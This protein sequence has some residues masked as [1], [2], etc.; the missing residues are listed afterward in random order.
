M[1]RVAVA[2][3][4]LCAVIAATGTAT[5]ETPRNVYEVTNLV[6]DVPGQALQVDPNLVNAWGLAAGPATPWWVADN[7]TDVSTLYTG[8]GDV[9]PLVVKV[10]GA[11]TGLVFNGGSGFVVSHE[12]PSDPSLF[13]FATEAGTIRGWNPNVGSE[14]P[15]STRS[16]VLVNRHA[17]GAVYK[18]LAIASTADGDFLY[19]TDF[20][21]AR[22][23]MFDASLNLVT[24]PGAFVDPTLPDGYAPFGIAQLGGSVFVT[25]AKQDASA[26]DEIAGPGLGFVD[27]YDTNGTF[28]GRV[29][30]RG[31]LNAPWGLAMAPEGFG[32]YGG[33]L[34]VGNFGDGRI[35]AF[36]PPAQSGGPFVF[37]SRLRVAGG[38][39][40]TIDGLWA[41][42][43]GKGGPAGPTHTLFFT[44][45]PDDES[46]GLFGSI[47]P[48]G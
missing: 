5:A 16:F 9:L 18:G 37:R 25:Y 3:V 14:S 34:L 43:F 38:D 4:V 22:V 42:A 28:L 20:H 35:L 27:M 29:G 1:R 26:S 11:P 7:G 39:L 30:S 40:L 46:H 48:A 17:E 15:P 36:E 33:D 12:G 47:V 13:L 44:A 41:L 24:P 31:R 19:A 32:R 21:N 45:G 8:T 10:A 2:L 6:S 23:D